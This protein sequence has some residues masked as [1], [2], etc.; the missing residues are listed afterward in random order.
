M[1][2][3][4][5]ASKRTIT[6]NITDLQRRVRYLQAKPVPSKLANQA[7]T[8]TAIQPRAVSTDQ[9]ALAAITNDQVAADAIRQEQLANLSVGNPE[10]QDDA[11]L[12]RNI[13]VDAVNQESIEINAIGQGEMQDNSVGSPEIINGSVGSDEIANGAVGSDEIATDAVTA[14]EIAPGAVGS[15]E[16]ATNAVVTD[17]IAN[18]QISKEKMKQNSVG[19]RE[20]ING[21]IT[22][23]QLDTAAVTNV[24]IADSAVT[25]VKLGNSAVTTAKIANSAVTQ[26][27]IADGSIN[28]AKTD[29]FFV[30][31]IGQSSGVTVTRSSSTVIVGINFGTGSQQVPRGNHTHTVNVGDLGGIPRTT[32]G[33]SASTLKVKKDIQSYKPTN[34]KNLLN[35]EPKTYRYK[36]S[37]RAYHEVFNKDVM[38]G[39]I[40]EELLDLG[41]PEPVGYDKEGNPTKLDYGL[42][43][44]LVLELVK[45][46][47]TEIDSLK[48][49]VLR[50][51]DAK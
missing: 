22:P 31:T 20:I 47:Q 2:T 5:R 28:N 36:R 14:A 27:K 50:L 32:S 26:D 29:G 42:M 15:A 13:A 23:A 40:V 18:D 7:V 49:E 8:R 37:E 24:K 38:H 21:S 48:E 12:N 51:K 35:L 11:V 44:L 9:I 45:V 33:P 25:S 30:R 39:Y 1:A 10:L 41:F 34:I 46:Q 3:R 4:R 19:A 16:L 6:G 43:S 17:K